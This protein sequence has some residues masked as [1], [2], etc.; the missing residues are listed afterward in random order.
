MAVGEVGRGWW[1]RVKAHCDL[2]DPDMAF[3]WLRL[4]HSASST[5]WK[6]GEKIQE[7]TYAFIC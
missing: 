1:A 5:V 7:T 4:P 6:L 2:F 3:P